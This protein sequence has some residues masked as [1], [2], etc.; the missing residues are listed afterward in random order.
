MESKIMDSLS[1]KTKKVKVLIVNLEHVEK[2][3]QDLIAEKAIMKSCISD[4]NGFISDIIKTK[5]PMITIT[6]LKHLA[7]KLRPMFAML[8]HLEGIP[9]P[10]V[11]PK[12]RGD[13]PKKPST[14]SLKKPP[15]TSVK[16]SI[17]SKSEPKGKEKLFYE[18][19]IVDN[20]DEEELDEEEL[21]R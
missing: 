4:V 11:I 21:K 9:E 8:L 5:D 19:P 13:Q 16:P 2:D 6:V 17:K 20:G 18:E 10:S 14:T 12:Q 7:E 3:I 1:I 15:T